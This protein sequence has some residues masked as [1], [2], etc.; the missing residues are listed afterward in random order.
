MLGSLWY[1]DYQPSFLLVLVPL[2]GC[3]SLLSF[4]ANC[5]HDEYPPFQCIATTILFSSLWESILGS[6]W[7]EWSL[8]NAI[9][10]RIETQ[11]GLKW[12]LQA[13]EAIL[14]VVRWNE[15]HGDDD[16]GCDRDTPSNEY[17][18]LVWITCKIWRGVGGYCRFSLLYLLMALHLK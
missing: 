6:N 7:E 3:V 13:I 8:D 4:H 9:L 11:V 18:Y 2:Y 14:K 10:D 1:M 17:P 5:S 16:L 15:D 12:R